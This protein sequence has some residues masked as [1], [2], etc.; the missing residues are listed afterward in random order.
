MRALALTRRPTPGSL[1]DVIQMDHAVSV[2]CA[3]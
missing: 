1:P 2:A 3:G